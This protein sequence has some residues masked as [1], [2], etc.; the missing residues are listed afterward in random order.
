MNYL[1]S[2]YK[3]GLQHCTI[4]TARS[5]ISMTHRQVEGQQVGKHPMVTRLM[6]GIYNKRPPT[7][8]YSSTWD[9][10]LVTS[11]I[12]GLGRNDLLDLKQLS[13]KLTM[14][15]A[16]VSANRSSE[17][18]ALDLRFRQVIPSKCLLCSRKERQVHLRRNYSLGHMKRIMTCVSYS[19]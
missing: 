14:L 9:V 5:A 10:R 3:E 17:L 2:L 18:A 11:Y 15:M 19:A 1:A 4:N 13:L 7:P 16:L 8:R 6:Q 12:K